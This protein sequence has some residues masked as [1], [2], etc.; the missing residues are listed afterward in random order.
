MVKLEQGERI[1]FLPNGKRK[2]IQSPEVFSFSMDAVLLAKF[3]YV[4]IQKGK[5]VDLCTGNGVI[6]LLLSERSKAEI[7]GVEIQERLY[8]MAVRTAEIN[9]LQD[10]IQFV[11]DDLNKAVEKLGK[12]QFDV[13]TCNPPYYKSVTEKD[14]NENKYFAI[15]RH[16]I[17]CSLDDV[18]RVSSE[19][20]KQKG[21]LAIVHRPERLIDIIMIMK[22]YHIEP[23]RIQFIHPK[24]DKEANIL[25]I[26]GIKK[27]NSGVKIHKPLVVYNDDNTYSKQFTEIY[28]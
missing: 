27:G 20:V 15:A 6:P 19:L 2:I 22:K 5:I 17:Y 16:E 13:V 4:P 24:K 3:C 14:W 23:K 9:Q 11:H 10:Q 26:E 21:K 1:D 12:G 7:I 18:I 8:Q 25:L 28:F